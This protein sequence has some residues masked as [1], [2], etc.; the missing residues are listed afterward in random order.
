M[1]KRVQYALLLILILAGSVASLYLSFFLDDMN[2]KTSLSGVETISPLTTAIKHVEITGICS[3]QLKDPDRYEVSAQFDRVRELGTAINGKV[4]KHPRGLD[5]DRGSKHLPDPRG[6][7][8]SDIPVK[9]RQ[10]LRLVS[11]YF[12]NDIF[13]NTDYYYTNGI[14]ASLL[15]PGLAYFP[16]GRALL[17]GLRSGRDYYS[18]SLVQNIYT[19]VN[20]DTKVIQEGDRPFAGYL[21]AGFEKVSVSSHY[22]LRLSSEIS[23]GILGP[24]SFGGFIQTTIHEIDPVGWVNQVR[25]D[26]VINYN[27][28]IVKGIVS[29]LYSDL[30]LTTQARVGTLHTDLAV[31]ASFRYGN[32]LPVFSAYS[33]LE[34]RSAKFSYSFFT[35]ISAQLKG[36]DATL[37]GGLF[38]RTSIHTL[39][40]D[41]IHRFVFSPSAGVTLTYG[42]FGL[43]FEQFYMT[44]EFKGGRHHMYG[45][46]CCQ[47]S[48]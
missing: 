8:E 28:A 22:R 14:K 1:E 26:V 23:F 39:G 46:V 47:M 2:K 43:K 41:E 17:P 36:Y 48:F 10:D 30:S 38:N 4:P 35:N 31:G 42:N 25:N 29:G 27:A 45:S 15:F 33:P 20:P 32:G 24:A 7:S 19:P 11:I 6:F 18:I 44:P 16:L 5:I 34:E 12:E 40:N 3:M 37:Q 9:D 13:N 21:M